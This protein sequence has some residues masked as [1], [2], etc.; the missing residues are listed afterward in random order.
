MV[1]GGVLR[2]STFGV[3]CRENTST[4]QDRQ[5]GKTSERWWKPCNIPEAHVPLGTSQGLHGRQVQGHRLSDKKPICMCLSASLSARPLVNIP[6]ICKQT[7]FT[8]DYE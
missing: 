6:V 2:L 4:N 8:S 7:E 5:R 1:V 3:C